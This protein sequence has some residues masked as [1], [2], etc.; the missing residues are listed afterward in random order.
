MIDWFA[1]A[2]ESAK[3]MKEIGQSLLTIRDENIIRERVYDLN[4][5]LLDLQQKLL[6]AQLSQMELVQRI[7]ALEN[8]KDQASQFT[9]I[10]SQYTIHKFPTSAHAYAL[11]TEADPSR[12]FCSHCL[13]TEGVPITLQ[14]ARLLHCPKCKNTIASAPQPP[15]R[16][17]RR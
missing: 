11:S 10:L 12:Y 16:V 8:E 13:E 6:E 5:S 2:V 3:A 9:N 15:I 7:K 1:G 4:N 14:G 17:R